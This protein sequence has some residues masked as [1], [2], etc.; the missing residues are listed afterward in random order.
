M[1]FLLFPRKVYCPNCH[2]TGKAK[3]KRKK[4]RPEAIIILFAFIIFSFFFLFFIPIT[5][6]YAFWLMLRSYEYV[7]PSCRWKYLLSLYHY[8]RRPQI[9]EWKANGKSF[10]HSEDQSLREKSIQIIIDIQSKRSFSVSFTKW[11]SDNYK[12]IARVSRS[13]ERSVGGSDV[14]ISD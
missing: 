14:A 8:R 1:A 13:P 2:Y 4:V 6:I 3:L 9:L 7:C 11:Q 5:L 12:V 10:L